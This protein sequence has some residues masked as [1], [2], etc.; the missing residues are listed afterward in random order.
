MKAQHITLLT[1]HSLIL[2]STTIK[3]NTVHRFKNCQLIVGSSD[4]VHIDDT[5]FQCKITHTDE[6][7]VFDIMKKGDIITTT[8]CCF[9]KEQREGIEKLVTRLI[10]QIDYLP[11]IFREADLDQFF[12][13]IHVNP[14]AA[15]PQEQMTVGKIQFYIYYSLL[16]GRN[17]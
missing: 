6:G 1:G 2:D 12:I 17:K 7:A 8:C 14:F 15:S 13:T 5:P 10:R 16:L 9:A 4:T 11:H 3:L